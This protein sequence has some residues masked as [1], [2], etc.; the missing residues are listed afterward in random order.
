MAAISITAGNVIASNSAVIERGYKFG[1]TTTAGQAVYLD[2]TQSPPRWELLDIDANNVGTNTIATLRGISLNGGADGQPAA[3]AIKD[4]DFTPGGTLTNGSMVY[5]FTTAGA[6]AHDVPTTNAY[7]VA[8]GL[9]KST[10]KMN[11]QPNASGAIIS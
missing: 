1:A 3:V 10:S 7:P 6:I 11:L 9:A 8:F 2:T 5:G 4:P